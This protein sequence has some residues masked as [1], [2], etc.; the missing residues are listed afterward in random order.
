VQSYTSTTAAS[1]ARIDSRLS[2]RACHVPC[3]MALFLTFHLLERAGMGPPS[4]FEMLV[5]LHTCSKSDHKTTVT[6]LE[7]TIA[8]ARHRS[9]EDRM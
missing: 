3:G 1:E 7:T 8:D 6:L 5:I 2:P 4:E 9:A